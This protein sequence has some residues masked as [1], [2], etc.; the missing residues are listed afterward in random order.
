MTEAATPHPPSP[1]IFKGPSENG[2]KFSLVIQWGVG[3]Q[4]VYDIPEK[5]PGMLSIVLLPHSASLIK[6]P[7]GYSL[8]FCSP[9]SAS[10]IEYPYLGQC[11]GTG[12]ANASR[13]G[14]GLS[15]RTLVW[16]G[17]RCKSWHLEAADIKMKSQVHAASGGHERRRGI[18]T[19]GE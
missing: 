10:L 17:G 7:W 5:A 15:Q 9:I 12:E 2:L 8:W 14:R 1:E 3:Q 4:D 16:Q 11:L 6:H 19:M 18:S 13:A